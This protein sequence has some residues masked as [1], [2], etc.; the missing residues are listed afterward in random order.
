[1]YFLKRFLAGISQDAIKKGIRKLIFQ[2]LIAIVVH[3]DRCLFHRQRYKVG[4]V[5]SIT[6]VIQ[7][8]LAHSLFHTL[9]V[10]LPIQRR[11]VA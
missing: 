6:L 2:L 11:K 5:L 9:K 1:M 3:L 4:N 8:C 7:C 10:L